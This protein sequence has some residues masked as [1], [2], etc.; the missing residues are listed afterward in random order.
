MYNIVT[1]LVEYKIKSFNENRKIVY[2]ISIFA[3]AN[4][5]YNTFCIIFF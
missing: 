5:T 4:I 1:N 3:V 2:N